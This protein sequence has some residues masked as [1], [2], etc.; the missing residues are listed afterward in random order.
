M[1]VVNSV[2]LVAK[3]KKYAEENQVIVRFENIK[4]HIRDYYETTTEKYKFFRPFRTDKPIA[5]HL[6]EM[7][8]TFEAYIKKK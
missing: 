3:L 5:E 6:K 4:L 1:D 8:G 2:Q 7:R